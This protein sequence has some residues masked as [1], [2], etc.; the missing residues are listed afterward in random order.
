MGIDGIREFGLHIL[1]IARVII[2]G[3]ALIYIMLIGAYMIAYSDSEETISKQK[4][5]LIN[6]LVAFLFLNVPAFVYNL[7]IA[8]NNSSETVRDA[9][10]HSIFWDNDAVNPFISSVMNFLKIGI[11]IAAVFMFSWGAFQMIL[12]RGKEE[13]REGAVNRI[14]YGSLALIF[15]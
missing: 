1:S 7:F 8:R 3:F 2:S 10:M 14:I 4:Q 6:V 5:Q 12:S 9:G 15:L 13:Y 11:F